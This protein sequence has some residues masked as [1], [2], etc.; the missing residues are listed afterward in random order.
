MCECIDRDTVH[1]C[2]AK[3]IDATKRC[4]QKINEDEK[5]R[6][7]NISNVGEKVK[8]MYTVAFGCPFQYVF[9]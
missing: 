5:T 1:E 9:G 4:W 8:Q 3:D 2:I 7:R 6:A